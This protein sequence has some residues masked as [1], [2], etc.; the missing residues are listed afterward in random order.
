MKVSGCCLIQRHEPYSAE[1]GVALTIIQPVDGAGAGESPQELRQH[2]HGE[3]LQRQLPQDD[4]G[5]R[6]RRVDVGSCGRGSRGAGLASN[7]TSG[8]R[9]EQTKTLCLFHE[10]VVRRRSPVVDGLVSPAEQMSARGNKGEP[11]WGGLKES[12][13]QRRAASPMVTCFGT[14]LALRRRFHRR[15]AGFVQSQT[16]S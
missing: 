10:A 7:L 4:H 14:L 13:R 6:D 2:V 9:G 16:L 11:G 12:V 3:L 5:Q 1:G 8:L 15:L